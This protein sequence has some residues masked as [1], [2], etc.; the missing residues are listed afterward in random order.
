VGTIFHSSFSVSHLPFQTSELNDQEHVEKW[1]TE[2][3]AVMEKT[4]EVNPQITH[5]TETKGRRGCR[6]LIFTFAIKTSAV[7]RVM[8]L[9]PDV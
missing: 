3:D 1:Q 4:K 8:L 6:A 7:R 5:Y 2:N 9:A